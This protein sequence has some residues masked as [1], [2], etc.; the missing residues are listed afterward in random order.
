MQA[1]YFDTTCIE[2]LFIANCKGYGVFSENNIIEAFTNL[3]K[4][5]GSDFNEAVVAISGFLNIKQRRIIIN[6]GEKTSI[7]IKRIIHKATAAAI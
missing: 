2:P 1:A 4:M 7:N 3:K 5:T 6:A